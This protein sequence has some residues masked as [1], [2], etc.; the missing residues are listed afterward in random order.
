MVVGN[1]FE[2][3]KGH[4][5]QFIFFGNEN[6]VPYEHV[7][8]RNNVSVGSLW[9][10]ISVTDAHD[11]TI[12]NN[13]VTTMCAPEFGQT[14]TAW[15]ATKNVAGLTERNNEAGAYLKQGGDT[16]VTKSHNTANKECVR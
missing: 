6:H 2:R 11:V 15:I 3:E 7:T 10:G 1:R 12:E 16:G 4:A 8:I 5:T 14:N 13:R 9:R